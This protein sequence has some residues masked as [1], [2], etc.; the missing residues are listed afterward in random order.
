MRKILSLVFLL[1]VFFV[2][3]QHMQF[4]GIPIDGTI[5]SFQ[6]KLQSKGFKISPLNKYARVGMRVFEG[7]FAGEKSV[8]NVYYSSKTKTVHSVQVISNNTTSL[9]NVKNK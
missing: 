7:V 3:A 1:T 6:T 8:I 4:M 9:E 5:N 2:N